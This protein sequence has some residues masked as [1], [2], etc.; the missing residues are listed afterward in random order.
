MHPKILLLDDDQDLLDLY[1]EI[2]GQLPS[3]PEIHTVA[4]GAR[5]ITLLEAEP[6]NILISDLNMPKMDGLQVLSIVRRKYPKLRIVVMTSVMDEQF[7][8]R[9]YALG[10]DLFWQK[11]ST[12]DEIKLFLDCIESLIAQEEHPGGFRGVQSKSLVDILQLECLSRSSSVLK[13]LNGALEGRIWVN[14]GEV[15]DAETADLKSEDAVREILSWK[16][17]NFEILPPDTSRP[18]RIQGS[19]QGLLLEVAQALDEAQMEDQDAS[20]GAADATTGT[21]TPSSRVSRLRRIEGVEF[22]VVVPNEASRTPESWGAENPGPLA[23]W[24]RR[25]MGSYGSLGERVLGAQLTQIECFGP[26]RNIVIA[27]SGDTELCVG[28][29]RGLPVDAIR[30]NMKKVVSKWA[31]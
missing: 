21:E 20:A 26:Q 8:S 15:V 12:M 25:T 11:P 31:S 24:T 27:R 28:W 19:Y 6:F 23:E 30:D 4:S 18:R 14:E 1:K 17:G 2:L 13:I 16:A 5:A 3:K 22:V 10:V 7:R 29:K 9:S